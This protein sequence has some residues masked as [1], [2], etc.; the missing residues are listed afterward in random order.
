[1]AMGKEAPNCVNSI[2]KKEKGER[3]GVP[4]SE[5]GVDGGPKSQ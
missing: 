3:G 4:F 5:D 1:M 2:D